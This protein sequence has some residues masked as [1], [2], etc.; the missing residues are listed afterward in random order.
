LHGSTEE[1]QFAANA[2]SKASEP[3]HAEIKSVL[4]Y[5][6]EVGSTVA[7]PAMM[8]AAPDSGKS[9]A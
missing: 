2:T 7:A 6:T 1:A 5:S 3:T 4:G 8:M 9:I